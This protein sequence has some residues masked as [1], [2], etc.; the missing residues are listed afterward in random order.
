VTANRADFP[1]HP[2]DVINSKI[3]FIFVSSGSEYRSNNFGR[4]SGTQVPW[5]ALYRPAHSSVR[6]VITAELTA[7]RKL[8]SWRELSQGTRCSGPIPSTLNRSS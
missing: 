7:R 1:Q 3:D 5:H 4:A 8:S 6:Q 2:D